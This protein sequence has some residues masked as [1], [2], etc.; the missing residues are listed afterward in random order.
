MSASPAR[1]PLGG[2][3]AKLPS[4]SVFR[5][6]INKDRHKFGCAHWTFFA[7]DPQEA[8]KEDGPVRAECERLHGHNY[9]IRVYFHARGSLTHASV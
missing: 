3:T 5:I 7:P 1:I 8:G 9:Y 2:P 6:E 4:D